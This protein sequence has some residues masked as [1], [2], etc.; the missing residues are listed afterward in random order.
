M[1]GDGE[2]GGKAIKDTKTS[3]LLTLGLSVYSSAEIWM[4]PILLLCLLVS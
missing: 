3:S 1:I 4:G 2:W